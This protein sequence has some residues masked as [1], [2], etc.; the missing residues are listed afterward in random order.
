MRTIAV[1]NIKGGVGKT[2]STVNIGAVLADPSEH[3]KKV[4][5]VDLD[6][7]ANASQLLRQY[8][9]D[10]ASISEVFLEKGFNA[11]NAVQ[12]TEHKNIDIIASNINFAFVEGKIIVDTS[13]QQ[14][15]RL[16]KALAQLETDYDYCLL[17]CPPNIG[18]V[19]I[20]ALAAA[21]EVIVP[22]KIDQFALDGLD[23]LIN[24]IMDIKSEFNE[25]LKFIGCFV[26]MD[27]ATGVNKTIKEVLKGSDSLRLFATSIKTNVKVAESTFNQM[28]VVYTDKQASASIGYRNLTQEIIDREAHNNV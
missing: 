27:N 8:N 28:P 15:T 11:K 24:T 26:T 18:I 5:I 10:G 1:I 9:I 2:I 3:N 12:K 6:P 14:Q 16:K 23:Y 13:R 25:K 20:N 17:D 4:L 19:T 22:I 21:D 7:Q